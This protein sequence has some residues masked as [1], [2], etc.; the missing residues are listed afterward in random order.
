MSLKLSTWLVAF[1]KK[2]H[3]CF[4]ILKKHSFNL[5][6]FNIFI[7]VLQEFYFLLKSR[8]M[9]FL[10][11]SIYPANPPC[12]SLTCRSAKC[13]MAPNDSLC[14]FTV[15]RTEMSK[16]SKSLIRESQLRCFNWSFFIYLPPSLRIAGPP[17]CLKSAGAPWCLLFGDT[18]IDARN[19]MCSIDWTKPWRFEQTT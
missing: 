9:R 5:F 11:F 2:R 18:E 15:F 12:C 7:F 16:T 6:V 17:S 8:V 10:F 19:V 3:L 1:K 13:W 14:R 4:I